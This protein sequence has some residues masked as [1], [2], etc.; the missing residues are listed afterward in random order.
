M[1]LPNRKFLRDLLE[2]EE[3]QKRIQDIW[4]EVTT[5]RHERITSIDCPRCQGMRKVDVTAE[6]Y[7]LKDVISFLGFA[8]AYGIGKPPEE[9][10]H[11]VNVTARRLEEAT[12]E[13]LDAI[14]EG[15]VA[16]ELPAGS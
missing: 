6:K 15:R 16:R 14:I 4:D 7:N 9:K 13:E 2:S 11:H 12:D 5:K 10:I 8:A 3:G 1:S